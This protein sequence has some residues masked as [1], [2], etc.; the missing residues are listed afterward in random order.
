M[1]FAITMS[2]IP[3]RSRPPAREPV[4]RPIAPAVEANLEALLAQALQ[5]P[6]AGPVRFT[7]WKARDSRAKPPH[8][9]HAVVGDGA[10]QVQFTI[11]KASERITLDDIVAAIDGPGSVTT[12]AVRPE[13]TATSVAS[14]R[15]Q[16]QTV[17]S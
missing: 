1:P 6:T 16:T 17:G 9:V 13:T 3:M 12:S 11:G 4:R 5:R 15:Q 8:V 2:I 7:E 10:E 14:R